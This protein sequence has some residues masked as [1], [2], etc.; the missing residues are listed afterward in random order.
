MIH[1]KGILNTDWK[2]ATY[3]LRVTMARAF[4]TPTGQE[5]MISYFKLPLAIKL[6][7]NRSMDQYI[8]HIELL[9]DI[10]RLSL[11]SNTEIINWKII[12]TRTK[13]IVHTCEL[14]AVDVP[15]FLKLPKHGNT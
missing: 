12:S 15:T 4:V 6:S 7:I 5:L 1:Y 3:Y 9:V 13:A 14:H 11:D 2:T 8:R 10:N